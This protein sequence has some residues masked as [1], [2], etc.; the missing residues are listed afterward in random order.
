[1]LRLGEGRVIPATP[2]DWVYFTGRVFN[3]NIKG[4]LDLGGGMHSIECPFSLFINSSSSAEDHTTRDSCAVPLSAAVILLE[5]LRTNI[6][7][8]EEDIVDL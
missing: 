6:G 7:T 1:M 5:N 2:Q 4:L 8:H 3:S